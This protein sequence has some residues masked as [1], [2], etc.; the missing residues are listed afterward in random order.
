MKTEIQDLKN[1]I[2]T[3]EEQVANF[4]ENNKKLETIK[5]LKEKI[6]SLTDEVATFKEKAQG[7]EE[8]EKELN[9]IK[10]AIK[11]REFD[12]FIDKQIETGKLI[13]AGR[14]LLTLEEEK[15]LLDNFSVKDHM[16]GVKKQFP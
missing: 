13:P 1:Q 4:K 14:G 6:S 3:L 16:R 15:E 5:S 2:A 10:I 9:D 11:K 12:D 8:I 7:K